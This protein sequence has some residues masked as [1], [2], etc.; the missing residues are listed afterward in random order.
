LGTSVEEVLAGGCR[1]LQPVAQVTP[2]FDR[3]CI[4]LPTPGL[5]ALLLPQI[6]PDILGRRALR[7]GRIAGLGARRDLRHGCYGN[8]SARGSV[9]AC[10]DVGGRGVR[11]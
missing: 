2:A 3:R 6:L 7:S 11:M 8:G 4:P 5:A 10:A 1:G 9:A